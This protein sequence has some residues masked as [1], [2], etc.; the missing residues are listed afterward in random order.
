M[1]YNL[2]NTVNASLVPSGDG[3]A[4]LICVAFA[5]MVSFTGYLNK[6]SGAISI[7]AF[8]LYA[9]SSCPAVSIFIL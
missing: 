3:V 2:F 7:F 6:T 8:T 1:I 5:A 9:I 4:S